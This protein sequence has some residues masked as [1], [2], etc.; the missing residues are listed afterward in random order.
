MTELNN[1]MMVILGTLE[2]PAFKREKQLQYYR[3]M[4]TVSE[5]ELKYLGSYGE[6]MQS[7]MAS[8]KLC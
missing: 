8:L 2:I 5:H 6:L 3:M 7:V 1:M 4:Y